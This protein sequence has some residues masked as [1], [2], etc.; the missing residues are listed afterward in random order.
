MKSSSTDGPVDSDPSGT[1]ELATGTTWV[2]RQSL[3]GLPMG[4]ALGSWVSTDGRSLNV[5]LIATSRGPREPGGR[6]AA[7]W[8][9]V[10]ISWSRIGGAARSEGSSARARLVTGP[11]DESIALSAGGAAINVWSSPDTVWASA[12]SEAA[13]ALEVRLS[14]CTRSVSWAELSA[15]VRVTPATDDRSV[16]TSPGVVPWKPWLISAVSLSSGPNWGAACLRPAAP[17]VWKGWPC[18]APKPWLRVSIAVARPW[19]AWALNNDSTWKHW[20]GLEG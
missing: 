11:R 4:K 6:T 13:R 20:S 18:A 7:S 19:R 10:G 8:R 2:R 14:P 5:A 16:C 15:S 9:T 3:I 1:C 17:L 12:P